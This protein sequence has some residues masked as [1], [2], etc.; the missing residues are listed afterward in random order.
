M[1]W[2]TAAGLKFSENGSVYI[3]N[4]AN[5]AFILNITKILCTILKT[6]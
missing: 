2:D 6:P 1:N 4:I 3:A 5:T